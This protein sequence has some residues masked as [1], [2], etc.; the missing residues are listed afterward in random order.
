MHPY[1]RGVP[2]FIVGLPG[3][4]GA[5]TQSPAVG[6]ARTVAWK[7]YLGLTLPLCVAYFALDAHLWTWT[8]LGVASIVATLIGVRLH[9]PARPAAWYLL[10]AVEACFITGDTV[11][12]VL[13]EVWHQDNPFPSLA[14]AFY[15]ALYPLW[16]AAV[17]LFIRGR[18]PRRDRASLLD[19]LI[20]TTGLGLLSWLYLVLP[21]FQADGLTLLQRMVSVAYPL[22]DVLVL[23][24][25]AR[26]VAGGG[27]RLRT[28][29][30]L[31]LGA[32]GLLVSDVVYGLQQLNGSWTLG[33]P[34]DAGWALF[35]VAYGTAALHPSS[36]RVSEPVPQR[37]VNVGAARMA[38]LLSVSLIAPVVLFV[39]ATSHG[40]VH[41]VT[42]ALF[43][44]ALYLLV[45]G[46]LASIVA[47]HR[48][49]VQRERVL[50]TSGESLVAAQDA[51][52]VHAAALA[53]TST[54]ISK[55]AAAATA[56]FVAQAGNLALVA[57]SGAADDF[58]DD[59]D[60]WDEARPGG[61]LAEHGRLSV[62]PLPYDGDVRGILVV[63]NALPLNPHEHGALSTLA[64]QVALALESVTLAE[65]ARK[66]QSEAHFRALIQNASDVIVV[67]NEVGQISYA[68]PSLGR[69]LQRPSDDLVGVQ[70]SDLLHPDDRADLQSALDSAVVRPAKAR[71]VS[72]WRLHSG[73]GDYVPFEVLLSNLLDDSSVC[74]LVLTMRDVSER[75]AMEENLKY[76]A[77]HDDLTGLAN[78]AL[79]QDRLEHALGRME[80]HGSPLAVVML[81]VD[82]FKIV[83]DSRG[84]A[85]GDE[86]LK[87]VA[88]RLSS[89]L[90]EGDTVARFGGDEFALL[91][92]DIDAAEQAEQFAVRLV[93]ALSAPL[94]LDG[95]PV[96]VHASAGVV[97]ATKVTSYSQ[98]E[99][100]RCADLAMYAAKDRGKGQ[101]VTYHADLHARM[102]DRLGR[103]ADLER[104][105]AAQEFTLVYQPIVA[106][107]SGEI[108][109]AEALVRWEH[110]DR[111]MVQP[112]EFIE[113]AEETGLIVELGSWVL[114]QAC[115]QT[116]RW[117]DLLPRGLRVAVNVSG[118][119]LREPGFVL[120]VLTALERHDVPPE[121]LVIELTE[122]VLAR[123]GSGIPERI[124][125][126]K[127]LGLQIAI[128]D[129]GTGYSSLAY[130]QDFPIDILKVDKSF[131]DGLA[132]GPEGGTLARAIVSL[133]HSLRL[134]VVAEGIELA[135]QH[136]QLDSLGCHYGQGYLFSRP[137]PAADLTSLLLAGKP[138]GPPRQARDPATLLRLPVQA[139]PRNGRTTPLTNPPSLPHAVGSHQPLTPGDS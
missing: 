2:P 48:Q 66:R 76:Q 106:L 102:L 17:L 112:S 95:E 38:V 4:R 125:A 94:L 116:R 82:D 45:L 124:Q 74:G 114:D 89:C 98:T 111:G 132:R 85:A 36:A 3:E 103:R 57:C 64:S 63:R 107:G 55:G 20:I 22:L 50:R 56:L 79:F 122:T 54:L 61:Y 9:R 91:L 16:A 137:V 52:E 138:L 49:S 37:S 115:A 136:S 28:V 58:A 35:Y 42:I 121:L 65:T 87:V 83:N 84:H 100:L 129:F 113:L 39:E 14:D 88:K 139:E 43:S 32:V 29:Q 131:V 5:R 72:D 118:R 26:L 96:R 51:A 108:V 46:R 11:Y 41:G 109:S 73:E 67:V 8:P 86:V 120:E 34:T 13:T 7:L 53:A 134:A 80:R 21:N 77:F 71:S 81:D 101:V 70:L 93:L 105:L 90:R 117:A 119:Q 110:P 24:M 31:V 62:S 25:I 75:R 33:G 47:D 126:L 135:V 1:S 19:A 6:K 60:L 59:A 18:S 15:L 27:L 69:A 92:E 44:A 99:I 128:D 10:A 68:T 127:D 123:D 30:W 12:T 104:A 133:G 40:T 130:L 97:V 23:S 78:R